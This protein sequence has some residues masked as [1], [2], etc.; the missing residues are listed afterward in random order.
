MFKSGS[1]IVL[2]FARLIFVVV[3]LAVFS[4]SGG[5]PSIGF[6]ARVANGMSKLDEGDTSRSTLAPEVAGLRTCLDLDLRSWTLASFWAMST[7]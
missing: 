5:R 7:F 4:G 1:G 3:F 6:T 2:T